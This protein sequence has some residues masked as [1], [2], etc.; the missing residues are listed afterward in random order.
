MIGHY[1]IAD[2]LGAGGMGE[3]WRARDTRLNRDVAI[4]VLPPALAADPERMARF[5]REAQVLASLNHPNIAV[6]HGLEIAGDSRALV[7]ELVEGETLAERI[8]RGAMPLDEAIPVARQIAE[9]LEAAHERGIIHR[10]LKPGNVMITPQGV[11]KLLDFGLAKA[12]DDAPGNASQANSPTLSIA[13]TRAGVLLGTAGYMSPEQVKGKS[14]DK[15]ADIWAFGVVLYEMLTG[16]QLYRGETIADA[17]AQVL[18]TTPDASVLPPGVR[19]LVERCLEKDPRLRLRDIGEARIALERS[20]AEEERPDPEGSGATRGR[21]P[22][23]V[24]AGLALI[25][26]ATAGAAGWFLRPDAPAPPVRRFE[27]A[28]AQLQVGFNTSPVLSP[29]GKRIVYAAANGIW[30][31]ELDQLEP[32]GLVD[33]TGAFALCWS[34]ES[35]HIAY[36]AESRLWKIPVSGGQP[37][38]VAEVRMAGRGA[39][40]AW[41]P[42]GRIVYSSALPPHGLHQAPSAG[43]E[44]TSMLALQKEEQDLHDVSPLPGG[45]GVLYAID[46]GNGVTDTIAVFSQGSSR[47]ILKLN[48]EHVRSPVYASGYIVFER[49]RTNPGL[50]AIPFSLDQLAATGPMIPIAPG[51]QRPSVSRDGALVYVKAAPSALLQF[52]WVDRGG[53]RLGAVG[54]PHSALYGPEISP[55]GRRIAYSV[56]GTN[57]RRDIWVLDIARNARSRQTFTDD[58]DEWDSSWSP[59]GAH[60]AYSRGA[61]GRSRSTILVKSVDSS[62]PA[63]NLTSGLQP[64]YSP[65]GKWFAFAL[66]PMGS[67]PE[68]WYSPLSG[69]PKPVRFIDQ[70]GTQMQP[71]FSPDGR[72]LA[73]MS[74][75][76]GR[77]AVFVKPFPGGEAKWQVS[78]GFGLRPRWKRADKLHYRGADGAVMEVDVSTR[79]AM[80]F[81][82]PRTLLPGDSRYHPRDFDVAPDGR[83]LLISEVEGPAA[84]PPSI[85]VVENWAQ[86]FRKK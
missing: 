10:D 21:R 13:A 19:G 28:V 32:R 11:V 71:A 60:L 62:S 55:D 68:L 36:I 23:W 57:D 58:D 44:L 51:G 45:R 40:T 47:E 31:R 49:E 78:S 1:R 50:W 53:K 16:R 84:K 12:L 63:K 15:R 37:T 34:P 75:E 43:G 35:S 17:L 74:D 52:V 42:D 61:G 72:F 33:A 7:M 82:A 26:I 46:R 24:L 80:V 4:K 25:L 85:V 83:F 20:P 86:E 66:V 39:A 41:L 5:E 29:D 30:I 18:T 38:V 48:D 67:P 22:T 27:I 8:A 3:V 6:L 14:A 9:A 54:E 59:S 65:D 70:K 81:G 79:P 73:Y 69:E 77:P 76:S 64:A 56:P 2:K